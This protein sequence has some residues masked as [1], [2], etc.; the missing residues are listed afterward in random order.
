MRVASIYAPNGNPLG[1]E[2]FTYKLAWLWP[3]AMPPAPAGGVEEPVVALMGDYNIIPEEQGRSM[4]RNCGSTTPCSSR[5]P[6]RR[7]VRIENLGYTD[8]FRA[9]HSKGD[10]YTFW[11][12]FRRKAWRRNNGIRIDHILLSPQGADRLKACDI[13]KDVREGDKPSDLCSSVV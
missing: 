5:N 11:D 6:R 10:R 3:A 4:I 7:C 12:Y 13:D 9:R 2:K 8:A 1:T